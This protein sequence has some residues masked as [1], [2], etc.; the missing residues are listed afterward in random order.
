[1]VSIF[2]LNGQFFFIIRVMQL[3]SLLQAADLFQWKQRT[4]FIMVDHY[5]RYVENI[6]LNGVTA[7]QVI[8]HTKSIF[9]RHGIPEVVILD[10]G[11][12]HFK[13]QIRKRPSNPLYHKWPILPQSNGEAE[14][15]VGT[16]K[17]LQKKL[18]TPTLHY[19]HL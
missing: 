19:F 14:R 9:A 10:N 16:V 18:T 17:N 6:C 8:T 13:C 3:Q 5:S 15:A 2:I 1:M 4:Y 12:V 7:E 11:A